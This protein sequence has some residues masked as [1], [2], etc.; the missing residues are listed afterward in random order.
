MFI[1]LFN[2]DKMTRNFVLGVVDIKE[3]IKNINKPN[4]KGDMVKKG[5]VVTNI[6]K[7]TR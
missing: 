2:E 4:V 6:L 7:A 1:V 5:A 3:S